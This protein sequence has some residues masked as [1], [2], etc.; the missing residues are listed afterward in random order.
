MIIPKVHMPEI[1]IHDSWIHHKYFRNMSMANFLSFKLLRSWTY[2]V[3]VFFLLLLLLLLLLP[4]PLPQPLSILCFNFLDQ[5]C[6]DLSQI[7]SHIIDNQFFFFLFC[8]LSLAS[9]IF[10]SWEWLSTTTSNLL[11]LMSLVKLYMSS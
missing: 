7:L 2:F 4:L 5:L 6:L 10:W 9:F 3:Y 11:F 8:I 1:F